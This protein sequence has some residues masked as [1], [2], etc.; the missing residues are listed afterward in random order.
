MKPY[1]TSPEARE[2]GPISPYLRGALAPNTPQSPPPVDLDSVS[3]GERIVDWK[4][5]QDISEGERV[6][7]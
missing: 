6:K 3:I 4:K 5:P 2:Q 1:N 7:G